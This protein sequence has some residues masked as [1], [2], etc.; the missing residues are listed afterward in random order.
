MKY[1]KE[2]NLGFRVDITTRSY[3]DEL[4][5][6]LKMSNSELLRKSIKLTKKLIDIQKNGGVIIARKGRNNIEIEIF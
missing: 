2:K 6:H 1:I 5:D 4:T 3:M